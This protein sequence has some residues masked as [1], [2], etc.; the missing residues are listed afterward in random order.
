MLNK[1]PF[2]RA[3][4]GLTT[5]WMAFGLSGCVTDEFVTLPKDYN[6][7]HNRSVRVDVSKCFLQ[8]DLDKPIDCPGDA[9]PANGLTV[10]TLRGV[11]KAPLLAI[12][13]DATTDYL[14]HYNELRP[15]MIRLSPGLGCAYTLQGMWKPI[16]GKGVAI[17]NPALWTAAMAEDL[18]NYN[19]TPLKDMIAASRSAGVNYPLW[20]AAYD[21][22]DGSGKCVYE[23]GQQKGKP[24]D[25]ALLY[26]TIIM[27]I[28]TYFNDNLPNDNQKN[29]AAC[30][31]SA[32]PW[33]CSFSLLNFEY[34]RDPNGAGGYTD[35]TKNKWLDGYKQLATAIRAKYPAK[36]NDV[37]IVAPSVVIHGVADADPA[38]PKRNWIYDFVDF[39]AAN[40]LP[41]SHLS[42]EVEAATPV[43]ARKIVQFVSK[44]A[45]LKGLKY[46]KDLH[47]IDGTGPIPLWVTD[48]RLT[49]TDYP[50]TVAADPDRLSA[51]KGA[52]Y[53]AC[54][55]MW[56][57][58]VTEATI[59]D[60]PRLP[61]VDKTGAAKLDVL[62]TARDSDFMWFGEA[63]ATV[64]A[65]NA[66]LRPAAWH[67]FWFNS[68]YLNGRQMVGVENG[69]DALGL[70]G[71]PASDPLSG[72][73]VLATRETCRDQLNN[74]T[75]CE[76]SAGM[77]SEAA[78]RQHR[79]R[80]MVA[81]LNLSP[82]TAS[83][84]KGQT[85]QML[86]IQ[87][88]K[89][90]ATTKTA[91]FKWAFIDGTAKTWCHN[92]DKGA[93]SCPFVFPEQGLVDVSDGSIHFSRSVGVPSLH[94]VEFLY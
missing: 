48:L 82:D 57:G 3:L 51:Y 58:L 81:D 70:S 38:N 47:G 7:I 90:P 93:Y 65:P 22:G 69:P 91:M 37:N 75:D 89:L 1:T 35:A 85:E 32:P 30:K 45:A 77:N 6:I 86:R 74:P 55:I 21:L 92:D 49:K 9:S 59:G 54:K 36:G 39:V 67:S 4:L 17:T 53:A 19:L 20:T 44:Y 52:F 88:E 28:A 64:P 43:E 15:S 63:N 2:R 42:F 13:D 8:S 60:V 62:K 26:A 87:I 72:L 66:A 34:G 24:I 16:D 33:D 83:V 25:N 10:A 27:R 76:S 80:V 41:L 61:T 78:G 73:I 94:Y 14:R 11:N 12:D 29:V 40:K 79:V 71:T 18:N 23:N 5:A 84:G 56:Q 50:A 68:P 31:S 46:E